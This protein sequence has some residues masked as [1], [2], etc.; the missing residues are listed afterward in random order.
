MQLYG[1]QFLEIE[2]KI[3]SNEGDFIKIFFPQFQKTAYIPTYIIKHKLKKD[4]N[5]TYILHL[6]IWFL[7]RN[8]VI[9]L[10]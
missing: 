7:K 6:P 3:V 5:G 9:P 2:G 1:D 10:L 8:R 4:H